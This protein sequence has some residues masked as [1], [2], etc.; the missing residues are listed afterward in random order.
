[1]TTDRVRDAAA[2][3]YSFADR[4]H[5]PPFASELLDRWVATGIWPP[6]P[7]PPGGWT[8]PRLVAAIRAEERER[9][10]ELREAIEALTAERDR[11]RA[12]ITG[13]RAISTRD[14]ARASPSADPDP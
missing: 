11:L 6:P 13:S 4:N 10:E 2:V 14:I 1:M 12:I 8:P 9:V 5:E 7:D 3:S